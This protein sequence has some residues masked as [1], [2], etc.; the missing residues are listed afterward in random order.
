MAEETRS[1]VA[2]AI[3]NIHGR[4]YIAL[5][6]NRQ[7]VPLRG[8][9]SNPITPSADTE[10]THIADPKTEEWVLRMVRALTD[11]N[12]DYL[13]EQR[14]LSTLQRY[15]ERL[16]EALLEKAEEKDWCSEYDEFAEEWDLPRRTRSHE[17]TVVFTVMAR[18]GEE[19]EETVQDGLSWSFD[20]E[21]DPSFSAEEA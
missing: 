10:V 7:L 16:G 3:Y 6:N 13:N 11:T 2:D 15:H 21:W 14:N 18:N 17:V 4:V 9:R 1:F 8:D 5:P 12:A 19:A 20:V